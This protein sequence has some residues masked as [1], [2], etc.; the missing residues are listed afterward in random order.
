MYSSNIKQPTSI[1]VN[2]SFAHLSTRPSGTPKLDASPL[3]NAAVLRKQLSAFSNQRIKQRGLLAKLQECAR[4]LQNAY[5]LSSN[6]FS[7]RQSVCWPLFASV[8][9]CT[10]WPLFPGSRARRTLICQGIGDRI[11]KH[12][13]NAFRSLASRRWHALL[14]WRKL[15]EGPCTNSLELLATSSLLI[16]TWP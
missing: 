10:A 14:G 2:G 3:P 15:C 13:H 6:C 11:G 4:K 8:F 5:L 1:W 12:I 7:S 16:G 9:P